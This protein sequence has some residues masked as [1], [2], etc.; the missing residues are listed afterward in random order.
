MKKKICM[1]VPSFSA[2][3]GITTVVNGIKNSNLN[4]EY[5]IKY[6]E[7]Y[8][9]GGKI[10]KLIKALISYIQY[11]IL[12]LFFKPN[13]IH[14]HMAFGASYYRKMFFMKVAFLFRI[15]VICHIHGAEFDKFY[16]NKCDEQKKKI[17]SLLNKCK[18]IIVLSKEWKQTF[19]QLI[20]KNK[21]CLI[22]NFGEINVDC[23]HNESNKIVSF[24]GF[25]NKRK[26][27]F[28]KVNC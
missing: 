7:S 21:I 2:K 25:I 14:V 18:F 3:G 28:R 5:S 17:R 6:I 16:E 22:E 20:D 9:D 11:L 12:L 1:I 19:E 10:K 27:L 8:C 23:P 15:P 26:E 4:D 24:T 13:L